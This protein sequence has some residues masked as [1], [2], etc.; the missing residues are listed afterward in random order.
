MSAGTTAPAAL[1][2]RRISKSFGGE[3]ALD[4]VNFSVAPGEIHGLLGEN[5]SGKSTLIKILSGYHAP[6]SGELEVHG[7]AVTLPLVPGQ[8]RE[9][10]LE[11][12]HQDL[13]LV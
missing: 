11:F 5:G 10:G 6:D 7:E 1:A 8:F 12:V 3:Q 4:D 13:G 2:M 9:L